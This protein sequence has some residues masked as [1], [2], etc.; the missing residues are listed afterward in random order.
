MEAGSFLLLLA[1]GIVGYVLLG[2]LRVILF[3]R[4]PVVIEYKPRQA[5]PVCVGAP[6]ARPAAC[7][8][9]E[10]RCG[11]TCLLA[12]MGRAHCASSCCRRRRRRSTPRLPPASPGLQLG[13]LT[14]LEL[15]KYDGRDPMRPL[16]L[17]VRGRVFDVTTGRAFYGPGAAP[18]GLS[19]AAA[20][21]AVSCRLSTPAPLL[22]LSPSSALFSPPPSLPGAGYQLFAGKECARALA[23]VAVDEEE[24][25]DRWAPA[26]CL[27]QRQAGLGAP[28]PCPLRPMRPDAAAAT[29]AAAGLATLPLLMSLLPLSP[30]AVLCT[31]PS[32][33][34]LDDLSKSQLEALAGW[35]ATFEGKYEVVGKVRRRR[36]RGVREGVLLLHRARAGRERRRAPAPAPRCTAPGMLPQHNDLSCRP[37]RRPR[38]GG[39]DDPTT[40]EGPRPPAPALMSLPAPAR[41]ACMPA[42]R[43]GRGACMLPLVRSSPPLWGSSPPPKLQIVPPLRL[44]LDELSH[45]GG[46]DPAKPLLLSVCGTILDVT[47]GALESCCCCCCVA[48]APPPPL[49]CHRCAALTRAR[50]PLLCAPPCRQRLLRPGRR[51]PLCRQGVRPGAGQ[52]LN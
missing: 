18:V 23:K 1:A 13:D 35:E 46:S 6:G 9:I 21:A 12:M 7:A 38:A 31:L 49:L 10:A 29:A 11:A 25:N 36:R 52:V 20:A 19:T 39:A 16:L 4:K 14:L 5:S 41:A 40:A 26:G 44:T 15:S 28:A 45:Y 47:A 32:P 24:C 3:P 42:P 17:A 8:A 51:L 43:Q 50:A 33:C 22:A 2:L 37:A 48:T 27:R 34:R 30:T